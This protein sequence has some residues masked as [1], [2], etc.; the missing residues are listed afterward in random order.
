M[1]IMSYDNKLHHGNN[2]YIEIF[3]KLIEKYLVYFNKTL[4]LSNPIYNNIIIKKGIHII[5]H[6]FSIILTYTKNIETTMHMC[7][8]GYYYYIE[9]INQISDNISNETLHLNSKDAQLFV[10]KKTIYEL[11][12]EIRKNYTTTPIEKN[13]LNQILECCSLYKNSFIKLINYHFKSNPVN[14]NNTELNDILQEYE[15]ILNILLKN[16]DSITHINNQL[17]LTHKLIIT[18][19]QNSMLLTEIFGKIYKLNKKIVLTTQYKKYLNKV[20]TLK[21]QDIDTIF[22]DEYILTVW[23]KNNINNF[24]TYIFNTKIL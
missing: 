8:K 11:D 18:S 20:A 17:Y 19:F 12:Q 2:L 4:S 6:L 10:Y 16:L 13:R 14:V 3:H 5:F 21:Y 7:E 15:K 23:N 24:I 1:D 22:S 9:F